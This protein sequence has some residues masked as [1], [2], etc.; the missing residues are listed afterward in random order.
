M[1]YIEGTWSFDGLP[2]IYLITPQFRVKSLGYY[3]PDY[4]TDTDF[5]YKSGRFVDELGEMYHNDT[6]YKD[7]H[8]LVTS[9][10]HPPLGNYP[11]LRKLGRAHYHVKFFV[12]TSAIRINEVIEKDPETGD[13]FIYAS[14]FHV[15]PVTI[16][17]EDGSQETLYEVTPHGNRSELENLMKDLNFFTKVKE[18]YRDAESKMH[19]M[20]SQN[21]ILTTRN[22]AAESTV[23]Q[24]QD[25]V[26][27]LL[28]NYQ[29]AQEKVINLQLAV[30]ERLR[31]GIEGVEGEYN[32][33][34]P[35][36]N[37]T[38]EDTERTTAMLQADIR[39]ISAMMKMSGGLSETQKQTLCL[40][41]ANVV[42][43]DYLQRFMTG[44]KQYESPTPSGIHRMTVPQQMTPTDIMV[45]YARQYQNNQI[46]EEEYNKAILEQLGRLRN[47]L[48]RED[49][50]SAIQIAK[51]ELTKRAAP[52]GVV[53]QYA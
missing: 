28:K 33:G 29:I 13:M 14:L 8:C 12:S 1:T 25:N 31:A 9:F 44:A 21:F 37:I 15:P 49:P 43:F 40:Q 16:V 34:I 32:L 27:T 41:V 7:K 18:K 4:G 45:E 38:L 50:N 19:E 36:D 53:K 46:S 3:D 20:E 17:L 30:K 23:L 11:G 52:Q 10:I 47:S 24:L 22:I 35:W 51:D 5:T 42:G 2:H 48:K 26:N 39:S 6:K